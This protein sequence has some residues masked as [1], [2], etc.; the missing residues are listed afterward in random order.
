MC[1]IL[2]GHWDSTC[3]SRADTFAAGSP[4][5]WAAWKGAG[6]LPLGFGGTLGLLRSECILAALHGVE[7]SHISDAN[8]NSLRTAFV[9]AAWSARMPGAVLCLLDGQDGCDPAYFVVWTQFLLIR[10]YLAYR[11]GE[12]VRVFRM[13][14]SISRRVQGHGPIHL[15][16]SSAAKIGFVWNS[17]E[18]G[19]STP[20]LYSLHLLAGPWQVKKD[21]ILRAWQKSVSADLCKRDGFRGGCWWGFFVR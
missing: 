20:S 19:W 1:G 15:L 18:C 16:L 12:S 4:P 14:D 6:A 3:R 2:E 8:L 11:P 7:S 13:L 5:V 17:E 10:G 9:A 21:S